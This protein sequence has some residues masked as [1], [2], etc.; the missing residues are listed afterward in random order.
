[1]RLVNDK[2]EKVGIDG[3]SLKKKE[4]RRGVSIW[5]KA[6]LSLFVLVVVREILL[7]TE[8]QDESGIMIQIIETPIHFIRNPILQT[9]ENPLGV[10]M[11]I[12]FSMWFVIKAT[13]KNR[14]EEVESPIEEKVTSGQFDEEKDTVSTQEVVSSPKL[15]QAKSGTR[16]CPFC[17]EL[18][19]NE[20][21]KCKHC[22]EWLEDKPKQTSS[23]PEK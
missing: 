12:V 2:G 4:K 8:V 11:W 7:Y 3:E 15:V 23:G 17:A 9:T 14:R 21:L 18:I 5:M 20:A 13:K 6:G 19:Q 16:K 22:G 10:L 1:M